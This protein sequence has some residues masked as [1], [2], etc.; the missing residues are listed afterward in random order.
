MPRIKSKNQEDAVFI[1]QESGFL[2]PI[3][4]RQQNQPDVYISAIQNANE[5]N[6]NHDQFLALGEI[7]E[8]SSLIAGT[9]LLDRPVITEGQIYGPLQKV[10]TASFAKMAERGQLNE[11]L[12]DEN[13]QAIKNHPQQLSF[14]EFLPAAFLPE[15][16]AKITDRDTKLAILKIIEPTGNS[17]LIPFLQKVAE[18][19]ASDSAADAA[20]L[21]LSKW[22]DD[23]VVATIEK[24]WQDGHF[25]MDAAF[26]LG[27]RVRENNNAFLILQTIATTSSGPDQKSF[28]QWAILGLSHS[29]DTRAWQI[30]LDLYSS[31]ATSDKVKSTALAAMVYFQQLHV[32]D[33]VLPT[34]QTSLSQTQNIQPLTATPQTL[35]SPQEVAAYQL[36]L[37]IK[38]LRKDFSG[39]GVTV[40]VIDQGI[41]PAH[42]ELSGKVTLAEGFENDAPADY[43]HGTADISII[44]G[45]HVGVAPGAHVVA[46]DNYV[47]KSLTPLEQIDQRNR[48]LQSILDQRKNDPSLRIVASSS[49]P[50]WDALAPL[51]LLYAD[52]P[53]VRRQTALLQELHDAGI[54][55]VAAAGNTGNTVYNSQEGGLG[56]Q[57]HFGK[58][59]LLIGSSDTQNTPDLPDDDV[60][61]D[62]SSRGGDSKTPFL[63]APGNRVLV[64]A[65][66]EQDFTFES[67]SSLSQPFV[68]GVLC[69]MFEANSNLTADQATHVLAATATP[70]LGY[71]KKAQGFGE[72]NPTAAVVLSAYL[73]NA[74][75][76]KKLARHYGIKKNLAGY[77]KN[78]NRK[79]YNNISQNENDSAE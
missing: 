76:G 66:S 33:G 53:V 10:L 13:L 74:Y 19:A 72:I 46:Y 67:G 26:A 61:N 42:S 48:F 55:K 21:I 23:A 58:H 1:W 45:D 16:F 59:T 69:L 63:V 52:F 43:N 31:P 54:I 36:P 28:T 44:V 41:H 18:D 60:V 22:G 24:R 4:K 5:I 68:T 47:A 20:L 27:N 70:L 11:L 14:L 38:Q 2:I 77:R 17:T 6:G 8:H 32:G 62:S 56:F 73:L 3:Q 39:R 15:I 79:N 75:Q 65:M 49:A 51:M 78:Y 57:G 50:S 29:A 37:R 12:T 40:A 64:A 35:A 34:S 9:D 25:S 71:D 7:I 30:F